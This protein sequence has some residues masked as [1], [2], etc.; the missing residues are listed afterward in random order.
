MTDD[1]IDLDENGEPD[2]V[3]IKTE[4]GGTFRLE[5]LDDGCVWIALYSADL[6]RHVFTV[7][8]PRGGRLIVAHNE[9]GE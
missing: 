7:S 5:R 9:D 8:T 6:T 1:R 4:G 2:D 3:A